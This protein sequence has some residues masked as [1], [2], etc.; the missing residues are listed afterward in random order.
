VEGDFVI[1]F[2]EQV[3]SVAVVVVAAGGVVVVAVVGEVA[4]VRRPT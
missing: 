4:V 2:C 1:C 3:A